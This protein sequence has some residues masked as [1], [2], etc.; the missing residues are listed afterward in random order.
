MEPLDRIFRARSI[1]IIGASN[2]EKKRGYQA[3]NTLLEDRY[4][5]RIYP[6]NPNEERILGIPCYKDIGDI[7]E[8]VDIVLIATPS[9]TVPPIIKACGRARVGGVVII[10]G[11]F[12]EVGEEGRKAEAE[13]VN[14]AKQGGLRIVGPNTSG[15]I[16]L[17]NKMNLVGIRDVPKGNIAMLTQSGNIALHLI[18]EAR[19]RSQEG[20]SFYVGVGNEADLRF[21]EYLEY[22]KNDPQTRA[23][24]LYVEGL[25]EGR[26]FLQEAYKTSPEKPIICLKSG[27]SKTGKRSAGSH[28]GALA[29]ISEVARTAFE[30]AGIVT[31]ENL[32]ELFPAA[33]SLAILPPLRNNRVAIL[34]DGGGHATIAAD[35]LSDLGVEI[36]ELNNSTLANLKRVL[37]PNASIGNPIDLAGS[38]DANPGLFADCAEI[39]LHDKNIGGLLIVGLFGGYGIRFSEKLKFIEEDTSHRM[40]KI[41]KKAQKPIIVH[42]LYS[43]AASHSLEL[44]RYYRIPVYEST[45]IACKC[46]GVLA[47][48]GNYLRMYKQK[49]NFVFHWENHAKPEGRAILEKA[50]HEKRRSLLE[51]EAGELLRLHGAPVLE[52]ELATTEDEAVAAAKK[53]GQAVALKV[54]S[55]DILHKSDVGGVKLN[56]RTKK[57]ITDAFK[58]IITSAKKKKRDA[59][60]LG[61]LVSPMV[62]KGLEVIIGT[63]IDDQFGPVIMFGLGGI[64]V[65]IVKDVSFRVLPIRRAAARKMIMEIKAA[66]LL[67]GVR[68][69]P[70]VDKEAIV[71]LLMTISGLIESYPEIHELDLNPVMVRESGIT[72]VDARIILHEN[73]RHFKTEG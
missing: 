72:I 19:L 31:I 57:E 70:P 25:R 8:P 30:R 73:H 4:E 51:H 11:G 60:I 50:K 36:P 1:A 39:L 7:G 49:T 28:T 59:T 12:G 34:A 13:I 68:G 63:K 46:I 9:R 66:P 58:A 48:Y 23:I 42:S 22:F 32:D 10:A 69:E 41:L 52:G 26:K 6:V 47:Q 40:G 15:I 55:P 24:V 17:H 16:S 37:P 18:T 43:L 45:D 61:C 29:G 33:E 71:S 65:E 20:F 67:D 3:I 35:L 62:K 53:F 54:V 5:G 27:R 14:L 56:L 44:L 21:H 2:D 38:T 64:L